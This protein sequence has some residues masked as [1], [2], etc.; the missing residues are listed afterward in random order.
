[1][2]T[3]ILFKYWHSDIL[4]SWRGKCGGGG[5]GGRGMGGF[6]IWYVDKAGQYRT[7]GCVLCGEVYIYQYIRK[8]PRGSPSIFCLNIFRSWADLF[9]VPLSPP[10]PPHIHREIFRTWVNWLQESE[11]YKVNATSLVWGECKLFTGLYSFLCWFFNHL[12]CEQLT[13]I[14]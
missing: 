9:H 10:P 8:D 12:K 4:W 7:I 1:M 2:L 11:T 6:C 14:V 3:V 5:E 13:V